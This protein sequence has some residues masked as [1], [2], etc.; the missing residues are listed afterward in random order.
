MCICVVI[1]ALVEGFITRNKGTQQSKQ[2]AHISSK[3]NIASALA[4]VQFISNTDNT[5][6]GN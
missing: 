6:K 2:F 5:Q 3:S 1:Q 4:I